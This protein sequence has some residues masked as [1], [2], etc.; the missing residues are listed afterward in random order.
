VVDVRIRMAREMVGEPVDGRLEGRPLRLPVVRPAV[1]EPGRSPGVP[2]MHAPQ[3][4]Q[5]VGM[6]RI[7][8]EIEEEIVRAWLRQAGEAPV[9]FNG[10]RLDRR[11]P[12]RR[13]TCSA[14]W[15][16][17]RSNVTG[18]SFGMRV[19][20]GSA[21]SAATVSVPAVRSF[22]IWLRWMPA[23]RDR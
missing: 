9:R 18:A 14:A 6:E 1:P 19:P 16:R 21:A 4:L 20:G 22:W 3:V 11:G 5:P 10:K 8:L 7:A 15:A 13:A 23:T 2:V 17:R 12:V